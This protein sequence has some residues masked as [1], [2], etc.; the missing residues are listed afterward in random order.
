MVRRINR[1]IADI[2]RDPD[3]TGLGKPEYLK[4]PLSGWLSRRIDDEHRLV[5]R[6]RGDTLEIAACAGHYDEK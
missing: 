2:Q 1:L 3:G 4:G 6:V 5:Y